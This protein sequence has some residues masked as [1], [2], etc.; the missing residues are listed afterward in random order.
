MDSVERQRDPETDTTC[1]VKVWFA[2]A[3]DGP[4]TI[5]S[6]SQQ[7]TNEKTAARHDAWPLDSPPPGTMEE[8]QQVSFA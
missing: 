1:G 3:M 4:G 2:F 5:G 7:T 8:Q 6:N